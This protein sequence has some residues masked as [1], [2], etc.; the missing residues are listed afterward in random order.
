MSSLTILFYSPTL[1]GHPQVYCRVIGE[2]LLEYDIHLVIATGDTVEWQ[3]KWPDLRP[4]FPMENVTVVSLSDYSKT[5][6]IH[7]TAEELLKLQGDYEVNST[8]FIEAENFRDEFV[9]IGKGQAGR[10]NGRTVGIFGRTTEWYPGE[11][12][13]SGCKIGRFDGTLRQNIGKIKRRI[14]TPQTIDKFFY[15]NILLGRHVLDIL[16]VK[17]ERL[18]TVYKPLVRWLPEIYKVFSPLDDCEYEDEW[19]CLSAK[20]N[21]FRAQCSP[22]DL[23]FFFGTGAWYKG[24]D[25]FIQ[26]LVQDQTSYGIHAGAGIRYEPGKKFVGNLEH[27]REKLL[28]QGRLFETGGYVK[29]QKFIDLVFSSARRFVS[30]HRLTV[31]SGTMLQALDKGLPVLVP[32]SG[33]IGYRTRQFG[34][35]RTYRYGDV[36]DLVRQWSAFKN[37]SVE[38]YQPSIRGFMHHFDRLAVEKLFVKVLLTDI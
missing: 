37:E 9:R 22:D 20:F 24:Y 13:Y 10:L 36:H 32:D 17:D 27:E 3:V 1:T 29:S 19:R 28:Q 11:E 23:L 16:I 38:K 7:L 21:V 2:I 14:F 31:S 30:T 5:S 18:A 33:L 25:Y 12:F 15:E 35:G 26:M 6:D 34:L 4:F 8:L